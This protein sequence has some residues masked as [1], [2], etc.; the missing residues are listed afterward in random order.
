MHGLLTE[1]PGPDELVA[2]YQISEGWSSSYLAKMGYK[3]LS[4]FITL[5]GDSSFTAEDVPACC[6]H[7]A[8]ETV[9]PFSGGYYSF[10][11]TWSIQK[12]SAVYVISLSIAHI[13]GDGVPSDAELNKYF[14][15]RVPHKTREVHIMEGKPLSVGFPVFNGDFIDIEFTRK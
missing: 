15:S 1:K 2:K 7:G 3:N 9:E 11:G 10:S 8:D 14:L 13:A 12:S 5:K 4:G 6:L